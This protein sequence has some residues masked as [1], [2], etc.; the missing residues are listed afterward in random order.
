MERR[1]KV[2]KG[3]CH[4]RQKTVSV[5]SNPQEG[6]EVIWS[7]QKGE[8]FPKYIEKVSADK[9]RKFQKLLWNFFVPAHLPQDQISDRAPT[10]C[11]F[12]YLRKDTKNVTS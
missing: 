4:R 12:G 1:G 9:T 10:K 2:Q 7:K 5:K 11:G 8:V 6:G 3:G